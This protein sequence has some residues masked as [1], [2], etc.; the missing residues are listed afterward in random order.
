MI[1]PQ[2]G[3]KVVL[4][5]GASSGIGA[6]VARKFAADG[7]KLILIARREDRLRALAQSLEGPTHVVPCDVTDRAAVARAIASLPAD[8]AEVDVLVNNAGLALGLGKAQECSLDDW[9]TMV[10]TN[11]R[12]VLYFVHAILPG[13]VAR[14][15]GHVISLG[16]IAAW[17]P[18]PGGN[19]YGATK[20]FVEQLA[21]NLRA[22][23]LG[24]RVRVTDVQPGMVDTEFSVVR[25][26]GDATK[27]KGIYAGMTPLT[28]DD[29]ANAIHWCASQPRHVNVNR[30]EIM[31]VEQA[32]AP[33]AVHRSAP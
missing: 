23:L 28:P 8:F 21:L 1:Q 31:P 19:V 33:T 18:Y 27:A 32:F 17:V 25:F 20:A 30:L 9:E 22:D 4:V 15:R 29:I 12:A 3:S 13:M 26:A 6:A 10:A 5:T 16:S 7:A 14:N 24:T 2:S 11:V